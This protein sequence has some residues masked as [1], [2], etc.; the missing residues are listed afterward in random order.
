[1]RYYREE[2][3][4]GLFFTG[5]QSDKFKTACMSITMLNQLCAENASENAI[6][7]FVLR[8]GTSS[9]PDM[10]SL[11]S[12][13]DLMYGTVIEPTISRVGEIQCIGFYS[14]FPESDFLPNKENLTNQV[15]QLLSE[16]LTSPHTKNGLLDKEYVESEKEKLAEIIRS[17]INNRQ[18]YAIQ[19][20]IEEMCCYEDFA[21]MSLGDETSVNNINYKTLSKHYKD[22]LSTSPIEI[23]YCGRSDLEQTAKV[24]KSAFSTVPRGEINYDI[25]TDIRMNAVESAPRETTD[26]LDISQSKLVIGFRMGECMDYANLAALKVFNCVYGSGVTS[27]LFMNVREKLSLCYY[28]SSILV[29]HK[30]IMLVSSGIDSD[31]LEAAKKEI[32]AQLEEI[33]NGNITDEELKSAKNSFVSDMKAVLDSQ[34]ALENFYIINTIDG[35]DITPM[36][37]AAMAEEVTKQDVIDIAK[38]VICDEI[39]FLYG[40]GNEED[41]EEDE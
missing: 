13:M 10:N 27:K 4:S 12:K 15:A 36:E 40:T 6:I 25:G 1:M 37:L 2:L 3:R 28:A 20:C 41:D 9:Y 31:N 7:P 8:R 33:K 38:S 39:Y 17:K 32:F 26:E 14:S 35:M 21:T 34:S 11:A 24:I 29:A 22:I 5:L 23:F 18:G 19:R 16:M 30:G